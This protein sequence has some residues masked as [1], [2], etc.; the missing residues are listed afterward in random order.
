LIVSVVIQPAQENLE[1]Y[2]SI[3]LRAQDGSGII[4]MLTILMIIL[5]SFSFTVYTHIKEMCLFDMT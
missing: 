1:S 5:L 2:F 3:S 4:D